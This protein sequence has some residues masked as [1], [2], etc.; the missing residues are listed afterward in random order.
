MGEMPDGG[1][2]WSEKKLLGA[3]AGVHVSRAV[4]SYAREKGFYVIFQTRN[5]SRIEAPQPKS[6]EW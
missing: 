3:V 6:P 1:S 4:R 2:R 5:A